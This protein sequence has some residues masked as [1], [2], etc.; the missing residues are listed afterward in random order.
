MMR[1][2]F[3]V[4]ALVTGFVRVAHADAQEADRPR[5]TLNVHIDALAGAATVRDE[6]FGGE[7]TYALS[8][9]RLTLDG[10]YKWLRYGVFG[11]YVHGVRTRV[12]DAYETFGVS[13]REHRGYV[14]G[15][16]LG[17]AWRLLRVDLAAMGSQLATETRRNA[18]ELPFSGYAR[19]S[20]GR[21]E[22]IAGTWQL[23][24]T[25]AFLMDGRVFDVGMLFERERFS[26]RATVGIGLVALP[27][28]ASDPSWDQGSVPRARLGR[29]DVF[30]DLELR[31]LLTEHVALDVWLQAGSQ[32][33]RG[34]IGLV[35]A[36]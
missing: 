33:P 24:S 3:M 10:D 8:G 13:S 4:V 35:F 7:A 6:A 28:L 34:R 30:T 18:Q 14:V 17:V 22:R 25:D 1:V 32:L 16:R 5:P 9:G 23:G 15:L 21:R 29:V 26:V 19:V 2:T 36:L 27:D 20:Y 11:E 31:A 12:T